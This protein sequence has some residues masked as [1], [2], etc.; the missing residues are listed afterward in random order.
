M[1][2]SEMPAVENRGID[3]AE[4]GG[5]LYIAYGIEVG[6]IERRLSAEEAAFDRVADDEE[7]GRGAVIGAVRG[8]FVEA[9]AKLGIGHQDKVVSQAVLGHVVVEV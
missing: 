6:R 1:L 9:A 8:V 4:I 5:E 3:R 7:R 2:S